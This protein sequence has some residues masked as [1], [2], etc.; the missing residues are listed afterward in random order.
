MLPRELLCTTR[1][2]NTKKSRID[3]GALSPL[4]FSILIK[5]YYGHPCS[6][7][8]QCDDT[9][10]RY[11]IASDDR[12]G[13]VCSYRSLLLQALI[14][15]ELYSRLPLSCRLRMQK[16]LILVRQGDPPFEQGMFSLVQLCRQWADH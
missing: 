13:H 16:P 15:S 2:T 6:L 1:A 5:P 12:C 8:V 4:I 7:S 11:G 10:T 14:G 9:H 3:M